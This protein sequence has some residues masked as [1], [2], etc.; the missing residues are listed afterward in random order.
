MADL[1]FLVVGLLLG[2]CFTIQGVGLTVQVADLII[3]GAGS[4]TEVQDLK[5]EVP[6]LKVEDWCRISNQMCGP[7]I[8]GAA[9]F[10]H[11]L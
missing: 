9:E 7:Q 8:R 5:L 1:A 2:G 10:N 6:D 4:Q 3:G 11:C